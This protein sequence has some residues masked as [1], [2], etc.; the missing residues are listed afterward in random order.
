MTSTK[1]YSDRTRHRRLKMY[2]VDSDYKVN[3]Q[4]EGAVH[5][6]RGSLC[7]A[8]EGGRGEQL[9]VKMLDTG[10][11]LKIDKEVLREV[12]AEVA[13]LLQ[14][15]SDLEYRLSLSMKPHK[16]L[17]LAALEPGAGLQV[18]LAQ[19]GSWAEGVLQYRGPLTGGSGVY[20]GVQLQGWALGL[21]TSNGSHKGHQFFHCPEGC[22]VF[23]P[24]SHIAVATPAAP[25][26][27]DRGGSGAARGMVSRTT[28]VSPPPGRDPPA[29]PPPPAVGQRVSFTVE[30]AVQR[31]EVRFCGP[32]RGEQGVFVG[33]LADHPVGSWDGVFK[34]QQVCSFPSPKYGLLLPLSKVQPAQ[35]AQFDH[36]RGRSP[37]SP[38]SH[39]C[40]P[41]LDEK[42][43]A[44]PSPTKPSQSRRSASTA[45]TQQR[46]DP[47][48]PAGPRP[49]RPGDQP[50]AAP[51]E[52]EPEPPP[53]PL[54]P[55]SMVEVNDPPMYGVIRWIGEISGIS[56]TVAGLELDEEVTAGT[57][58]SYLGERYFR[59]A[60]NRGL[61][62]K[63]KNC[64][65]DSR[66]PAHQAQANP[67]ERCNS[68]AFADWA[69]ERVEEN[70]P[71]LLGTEA[72]E[73]F[74]GWKRGIQGNCNS[75]YL[76][77]S[78]FCL[79]SF[80]SA[81]DS[82]LLRPPGPQ[83]DTLY[84]HT[85]DLLRN[86][87]V[88]PLR[89]YGYV[90]ATKVMALRKVLETP[91]GS[92]GF[93]CEE[94]DPEE[95]LNKLFQLLRVEPLL[96]IRSSTQKPQDCFLY[97]LFP[98]QRASVRV[99]TVQ[100]LLEWSFVQADLK[101]NE[102]PSCLMVLMPR[103]GKDYKMFDAIMPSLSLD[104]TD[105]LDDTLR[106]CS[107]CQAVAVLECVQCYEDPDI[108]P[109]CIKQFCA[110]CCQQVHSHRRRLS[111]SPRRVG[112]PEGWWAGPGAGSGPRARER[113][114]LFAVLCIETSHYVSFVRHGPGD[115]DWLFFDSMADRE[116]GQ[117]GFNI[118]QVSPCPEVA[119]Y[120]RLPEAQLRELDPASLQGRPRRLLCDAYMCLYH[121]PELSLYK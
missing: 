20:F 67:V 95:F 89:R 29:P 27:R 83:D 111:H 117:N 6:P 97:Q 47:P 9:W 102:A 44:P 39:S 21:G 25:A 80:S 30:S 119:P 69:S 82:V 88:N 1:Q 75:C 16:L 17:R 42:A 53:P 112:V 55:G 62:V 71:P 91:G 40:P 60:A 34:G 96:K 58:G 92:S 103:F 13:H 74:S 52:A 105:L 56:D 11:V 15:V 3:D 114:E 110:T 70:T 116:G 46:R 113:L 36:R 98:Q 54:E 101:F 12:S 81:V 8:Q 5:V 57:D 121:S 77:A 72:R 33:I 100:R 107:V 50:R 22:A 87:I 28:D 49:D 86:E 26:R 120:L 93:I 94:K 66:F 24:V 65:P 43:V 99:P 10:S 78:L 31:G 48:P 79:F 85:Q 64:R 109:G 23:V 106:Q 76:D 118:P 4:L 108:T 51:G 35:T 18:Q 68:I 19:S 63:L 115:E 2:V 14:P 59:C 32:L 38:S 61:F 90:C 45:A 73:R 84:L 41:P 7:Q 37:P 104:I